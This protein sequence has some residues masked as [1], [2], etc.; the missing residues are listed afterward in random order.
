MS[1]AIFCCSTCSLGRIS[2]SAK[3]VKIS[4]NWHFTLAVWPVRWWKTFRLHCP[5][6]SPIVSSTVECHLYCLGETPQSNQKILSRE[7]DSLRG[8]SAARPHP[9]NC[10]P[11]S[12]WMYCTSGISVG[13]FTWST[14]W[15]STSC[16]CDSPLL[17]G[18]GQY[19]T[20]LAF[21]RM[22][23]S[24]MQLLIS[25]ID[26]WGHRECTQGYTDISRRPSSICSGRVR[27]STCSILDRTPTRNHHG[28]Q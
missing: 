2:L 11:L 10:Y 9:R 3:P 12:Q 1:L 24:L 16:C 6:T 18:G 4:P 22:I 17:R 15:E 19:V 21:I 7:P 27:T 8:Q 13:S 25:A 23:S 28:I 20:P 14:R 5:S 26:K